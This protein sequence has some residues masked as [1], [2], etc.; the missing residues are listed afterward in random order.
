MI[1]QQTWRTAGIVLLVVCACMTIGGVKIE[2]L[3]LWLHSSPWIFLTYW[4]VVLI[5]LC[6]AIYIAFLDMR[7]IKAD[8]AAAKR[9]AFLQ[10]LGEKEFRMTLISKDSKKKD[11][12]SDDDA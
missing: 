1:N 2:A 8:Y 3:R 12:A 7:F 5:P 6:G 9:E 10:T 4:G 11:A